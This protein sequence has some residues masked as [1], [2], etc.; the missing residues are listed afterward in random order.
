MDQQGLC[1]SVLSMGAL[2]LVRIATISQSIIQYIIPL[3]DYRDLLRRY[4]HPMLC[5][6]RYTVDS[7]INISACDSTLLH[8]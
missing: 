5:V 4:N 2:Q 8:R 7:C 3:S 6:C 1:F